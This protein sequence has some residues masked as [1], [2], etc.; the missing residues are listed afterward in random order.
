MGKVKLFKS[1]NHIFG[2]VPIIEEPIDLVKE[3]EQEGALMDGSVKGIIKQVQKEVAE[4]N[5]EVIEVDKS[6]GDDEHKADKS[7]V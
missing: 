4:A 2:D 3:R 7:P 1:H 5:R 6:D